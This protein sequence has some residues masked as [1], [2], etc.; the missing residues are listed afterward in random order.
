M[1]YIKINSEKWDNHVMNGYVWT[2]QVSL[3]IINNAKNG[4][5]S[6]ELTPRKAIPKDLFPEDMKESRRLRVFSS[7]I[8][9]MI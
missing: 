8:H 1:D 6:L 4:E 3:E 5:W 2:K 9:C 7:R